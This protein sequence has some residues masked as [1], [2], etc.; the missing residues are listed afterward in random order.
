MVVAKLTLFQLAANSYTN[1]PLIS[2]KRLAH[3]IIFI[4]VLVIG[5]Y[6]QLE[7]RTSKMN[8]TF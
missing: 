7:P 4:I 3:L 8:L 5:L 1:G 2:L 6:N